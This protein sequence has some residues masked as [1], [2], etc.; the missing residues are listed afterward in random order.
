M[1]R[2]VWLWIAGACIILFF[3]FRPRRDKHKKAFREL[4]R[5][6]KAREAL[7]RQHGR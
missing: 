5:Q 7:K 4:A 1:D 6:E 3:S 2:V